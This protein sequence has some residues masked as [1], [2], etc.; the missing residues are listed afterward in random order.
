[1]ARRKQKKLPPGRRE[2]AVEKI[3]GMFKKKHGHTP[4]DSDAATSQAKRFN[5]AA[6]YKHPT[7]YPHHS[8]ANL[9]NLIG[10]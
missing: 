5:K 1:M 9:N 2:A 7:H 6:K 10:P 4:S 3:L 8:A